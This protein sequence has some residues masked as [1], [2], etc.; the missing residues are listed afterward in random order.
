MQLDVSENK[1]NEVQDWLNG[2][3]ST[4]IVVV[5]VVMALGLLWQVIK[6]VL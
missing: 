6:A 2:P 1:N 3:G 5:I 4:V